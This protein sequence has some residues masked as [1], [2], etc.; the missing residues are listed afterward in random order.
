VS[1][2]IGQPPR[3]PEPMSDEERKQTVK[4]ADQA[5]EKKGPKS[6]DVGDMDPKSEEF[7]DLMKSNPTLAQA[8][9]DAKVAYANNIDDGAKIVITT[10][11]GSGG[12]PVAVMVP[13]GFDPDQPAKLD[14]FFHGDNGTIADVVHDNGVSGRVAEMQSDDPQ[15]I[16]VLPE[17]GNPRFAKPGEKS[18]DNSCDW[19]NIKDLGQVQADAL[20]VAGAQKGVEEGGYTVSAHSGGG[21]G[22][23]YAMQAQ[24]DA[25]K[26]GKPVPGLK[27][28]HLELLDCIHYSS[29]DFRIENTIAD[30][31]KKHGDQVMDVM[32][33]HGTMGDPGDWN[34]IRDA[35]GKDKYTQV[36]L[37][38]YQ[39]E[40]QNPDWNP[41]DR[42]SP[43][44]IPNPDYHPPPD[45]DDVPEDYD[46]TKEQWQPRWGDQRIGKEVHR[47][48]KQE[49]LGRGREKYD[50]RKE[51]E[52]AEAQRLARQAAD[53]EAV[54]IYEE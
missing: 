23:M 42:T 44:K 4:D 18:P 39:T 53:L 49:W 37:S 28:D 21:H 20:L 13:P 24:L 52:L 38:P 10:S 40:I 26:K 25:E 45:K 34:R 9:A 47:R 54:R 31:G 17:C 27:V 43:R 12:K 5:I 50:E 36:E 8:I 15:R 2:A 51:R 46:V 11:S 35:F 22:I 7:Q 14:T 41:K 32:G 1:D 29:T 30:W 3:G 48:A 6:Y 19:S 33:V 16:V